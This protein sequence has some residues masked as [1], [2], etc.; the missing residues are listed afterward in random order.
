MFI[1]IRAWLWE[2]AGAGYAL[3]RRLWSLTAIAEVTVE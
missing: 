3:W 1:R 2:R